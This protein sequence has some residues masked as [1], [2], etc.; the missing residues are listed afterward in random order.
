M[1]SQLYIPNW[2]YHSK[3]D[4]KVDFVK[5]ENMLR[6]ALHRGKTIMKRTRR[7]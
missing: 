6:R 7:K 3:K 5:K 1:H 2:Q 4:I